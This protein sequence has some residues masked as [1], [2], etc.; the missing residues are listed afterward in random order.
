VTENPSSYLNRTTPGVY[1]AEVDAF[2]ASITG[3][4]TAVPLF[5]GYTQFA[6]DPENSAA[7]YNTPVAVT[8]LADFARY[9]GG[10]AP[11]GAFNLA[12]QMQL[13][14][15]NGGGQALIVSVGSYWRDQRPVAAPATV[16]A[17]WSLDDI[18]ADALIGGLT[19]ASYASGPTMLVVP[20][21]CLLD[22]AGYAQVAQAMLNQA[23]TLQDRM[24][25]LDLP[26]CTTA[27]DLC[28]LQACQANLWAAIAPAIASA[29]YGAAYAPA[30]VLPDGSVMPPSGAMA[31][32]YTKSDALNGVWSAPANIAV[33]GVTGPAYAMTDA[34]QSEFN[35][36]V[37]GQA[38][39]ILRAQPNRGTV[40]WGARTLDGNSQDY[41]YVQTR[42]TLIYIEQSIKMALQTYVFAANDATTWASVTAAI[43]NFLTGLWQQGGLV[44]SKPS[45]A[46][47]VSCGLNSM[48]AQSI[49]D[50]YMIVSVEVAI[51]H[52]AEFIA[53]IFRQSMSS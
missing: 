25:I 44:G 15:A 45:D 22:K 13:F 3:V 34:E 47:S 50:G 48:T 29:S 6:G 27:T 26:G 4:E 37:N 43:S 17:D 1:I 53:L 7:L 35:M 49:L 14:Y 18:A 32:I 31:G 12:T 38:V 24:A 8:S 10:T 19:A 42:R 23:S 39:G 5:V 20:E 11:G 52:P 36:P 21:A 46:F 30:L 51:V 33:A 28:A 16:P 9:F 40:F 2:G 41:R